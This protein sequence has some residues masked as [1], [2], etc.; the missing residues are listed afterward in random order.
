MLIGPALDD[1]SV[2]YVHGKDASPGTRE[3]SS[4]ATALEYDSNALV[5]DRKQRLRPPCKLQP[6]S[7]LRRIEFYLSNDGYVQDGPL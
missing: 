4:K 5:K 7:D 6:T 2:R 1:G 3:E